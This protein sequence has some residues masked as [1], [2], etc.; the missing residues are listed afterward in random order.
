MSPGVHCHSVEMEG[1]GAWGR[2]KALPVEEVGRKFG[3][4]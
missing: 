2:A 1:G 3:A 4:M